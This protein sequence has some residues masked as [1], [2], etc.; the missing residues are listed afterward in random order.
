MLDLKPVCQFRDARPQVRRKPLDCQQKL[1]L[2]G[3]EAGTAGGTL[4]E[5]Q[6]APNLMPEFG[7]RLVIANRKSL[8]H[9]RI[10]SFRA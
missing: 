9:A 8:L 3:L 7:Q 4:A 1:I 6:I 2:P 10:I 5:M